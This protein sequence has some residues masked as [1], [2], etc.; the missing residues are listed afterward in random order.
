METELTRGEYPL[1]KPNGSSTALGHLMHGRE[2]KGIFQ[3]VHRDHEFNKNTLRL[4][5]GEGR[6]QHAYTVGGTDPHNRDEDA[7]DMRQI[8]LKSHAAAANLMF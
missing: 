4:G 1:L 8:Q 6:Q 7:Q 3:R 2:A 5:L